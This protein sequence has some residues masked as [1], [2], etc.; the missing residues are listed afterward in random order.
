[1]K[2]FFKSVLATLFALLIANALIAFVFFGI[3][4]AVV[5]SG[6][7]K[8]KIKS[9]SVLKLDFSR[10]IPEKTDN[11]ASEP[12]A[13]GDEKTIGLRDFVAAIQ[14]AKSDDKIKGIYLETDDANMG[15]ATAS[16]IRKA[17]KEFRESGKFVVAYHELGYSQKSYYLAS[18]GEV[19]LHPMGGVDFRGF[20]AEVDFIKGTL[21]KLGVKANVFYCGK[22]KSATEPIRR[23]DMSE[24]NRTQVRELLNGAYA[25]YLAD[26]S[27]SRNIPTDRLLKIADD[28]LGREAV[29]A[30]N[31]GLVD[32]LK[33]R[34]EV[35]KLLREKLGI[36]EKEEIHTVEM[37][38]YFQTVD[39]PNSSREKNRIAIV[40]CEGSIVDGS[41]DEPGQIVGQAYA[42]IIRQLRED[43][44][45]KVIVMRINSGGG[46]A[47][48][49]ESIWR[50]LELAKQAGKVVVSTMG[51]VAASGGYY[52]A[53]NSQRIFAEPNTI[54]GSIGVFGVIPNVRDFTNNTL[55]VT[56]DTVRTGRFSAF[57]PLYFEMNEEESN[58]I[59]HSVD[60]TYMRFKSR[61]VAGRQATGRTDLTLERLEEIAQGR[62]WIGTKALEIG[63]V[64]EMGGLPAAI[65]WAAKQANIQNYRVDEYPKSP[66]KWERLKKMFETQAAAEY[67]ANAVEA[68]MKDEFGLVYRYYETLRYVRKAKGIQMRMPYDLYIQ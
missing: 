59:Q 32:G 42:K 52:I 23:T 5:A 39:D 44:E 2:S 45:V 60:S 28:F 3:I 15:L 26:V 64:D 37:A 67:A 63:L 6:E 20:G 34:D 50:E 55:G 53:S 11:L 35:L 43:D 61:V 4:G 24:E 1:M 30:Q 19:Y 49:S 68:K 46:S 9:N 7:G 36:G 17:L 13:F 57:N 8:T 33:Y 54:T 41:E 58:M 22:F 38:D 51:D 65:E 10:P 18:V 29:P 31:A 48:A 62:V 21:D 40:N 27:A 14:H 25:Q 56:V 12:F 66:D 16:V 47:L